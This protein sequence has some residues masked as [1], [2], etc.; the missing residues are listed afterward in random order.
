VVAVEPE[1]NTLFLFLS[2]PYPTMLPV[3]PR[4]NIALPPR[5]SLPGVEA[6]LQNADLWM[7]FHDIGTEMIITKSGR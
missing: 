3:P 5:Y 7:Q 4:H 1:I 2:E 6:K